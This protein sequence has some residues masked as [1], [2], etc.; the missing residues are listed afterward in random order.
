MSSKPDNEKHLFATFYA[1][2]NIL[3]ELDHFWAPHPY[4]T[5]PNPVYV[6][7]HSG[8]HLEMELGD[9]YVS[10]LFGGFI[11]HSVGDGIKDCGFDQGMQGERAIDFGMTDSGYDVRYSM[12]ISQTERMLSQEEWK[13]HFR[14]ITPAAMRRAMLHRQI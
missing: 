8:D 13:M 12:K 5:V 4:D 11:P 3:H 10:W 14:A 2:I 6:E 7:P 1:A 9:A